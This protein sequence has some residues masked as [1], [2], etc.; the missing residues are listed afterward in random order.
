MSLMLQ[1]CLSRARNT[2]LSASWPM[3]PYIKA[4]ILFS[5]GQ[6]WMRLYNLRYK[7]I[8]DAK[9]WRCAFEHLLIIMLYCCCYC[10]ILLIKFIQ[11][12]LNL[13]SLRITV[14]GSKEKAANF[15]LKN[16][17]IKWLEI[18]RVFGKIAK[19]KCC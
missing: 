2:N 4:F 7:R 17:K 16:T 19:C 12:V 14:K 3:M 18:C 1:K 9:H 11:N 13:I 10:L 5:D 15:W 8:E 6:W